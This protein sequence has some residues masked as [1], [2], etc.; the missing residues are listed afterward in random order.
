VW[1]AIRA[2]RTISARAAPSRNSLINILGI[3]DF[4]QDEDIFYAALELI[5]GTTLRER[6]TH[7]PL[8]KADDI[9]RR[10]A[11]GLSAAHAAGILHRDVKPERT[12][13]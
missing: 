4:G 2:A 3:Y 5:E 8:S 1:R 6:M 12:C 11:R 9:A 10:I 13:Y 7:G